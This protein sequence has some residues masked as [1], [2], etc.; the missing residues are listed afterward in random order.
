MNRLV[1]IASPKQAGREPRRI[2]ELGIFATGGGADALLQRHGSGK[3]RS[4][5]RVKSPVMVS[6]LLTIARLEP[7]ASFAS[8]SALA[9]TTR[10]QPEQQPRA[11]GGDAHRMD[12]LGP[13]GDPDMAVDGTAFLREPGH[14]EH[15]D[16]LAFEMRGHAEQGPDGDDAGAADAGDENA[17]GLRERRLHR[18]G[19]RRQAGP[20]RDRPAAAF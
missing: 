16:A 11:A 19:Q 6:W 20:R 7:G 18:L 4:G 9:E 12:R 5:L 1:A 13:P 3:E 8:A 14:V 15:G 2:D 17:V 10:S